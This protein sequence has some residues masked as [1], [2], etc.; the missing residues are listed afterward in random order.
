MTRGLSAQKGGLREEAEAD[1]RSILKGNPN[2]A[3]SLHNLA[4]LVAAKKQFVEAIQLFEKSY[5]RDPTN[6]AALANAIY[7]ARSTSAWIVERTYASEIESLGV[8]SGV[9]SPFSMLA[10]DD[11]PSRHQARSREY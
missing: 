8:E 4:T 1:F 3:D 11:S 10:L 7:Y 6:K 9:I 2:H 5:T